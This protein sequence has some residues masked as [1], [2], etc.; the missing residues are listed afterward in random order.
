[1]NLVIIDDPVRPQSRWRRPK[2]SK[3]RVKKLLARAT[4][5]LWSDCI[6]VCRNHKGETWVTMMD[7]VAHGIKRPTSQTEA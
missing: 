6:F 1:M 7:I 3:R 2:R 5:V 4:R